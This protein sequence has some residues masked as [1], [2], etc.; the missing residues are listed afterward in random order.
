MDEQPVR[1]EWVAAVNE[2]ARTG[3]SEVG[4]PIVAN[5]ASRDHVGQAV[6]EL[7]L[8]QKTAAEACAGADK[9]LDA[10]IAKD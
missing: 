2:L 7:L 3:T 5:P 8:G 1:A 4:Y 6:Q 9:Q 10:L